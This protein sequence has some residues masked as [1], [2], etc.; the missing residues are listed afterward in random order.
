MRVAFVLPAP[1]R[2]PMGGVSVV[3][4]HAAGLAERGHEVMVVA[5]QRAP[6]LWPRARQLAVVA[7]DVAHGVA[8]R[9]PSTPPGVVWTEPPTLREAN[10]EHADVVI[11]TG[12]QTA[13]WVHSLSHPN[14]HYFIQGD[15]RALSERAAATWALPLRRIAIAEWLADLL[16]TSG[17][18]VEGVVPNAVDPSEM[19]SK[20]PA[21]QRPDRVIALY[22]RHPVKGPGTLIEALERLKAMVPNVGASIVAARPPSHRLP[23]WV[24]L[25]VR[26]TR[27]SLRELYD[28]AAVCLHTSRVEGW[29]LVPMEAAACG[30]AI[31]AT[32]SRGPREY[33]T[34]D[35]SMLEVPVGAARALAD[36]AARV[37]LDRSL[38]ERLSTA[39]QH[40]VARFTWSDSTDR[41]ESLL[42]A[43]S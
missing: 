34:P 20:T 21:D 32:A 13:P 2:V 43:E 37:L 15:E 40:D 28:E 24:D 36:E 17:Y 1:A 10:L 18:P 8:S 6:G 23:D 5:P 3:L 41:L 39:A 19:Y 29:G 33:L 7:R 31:V 26:P 27:V 12:Y 4:R 38:R 25:Y 16:S 30:C 11:A 14:A 9:K 42:A 35:R 22:H